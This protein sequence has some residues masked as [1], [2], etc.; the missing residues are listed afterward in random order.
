MKLTKLELKNYKSHKHY[1]ALFNGNTIIQGN[2]G[3][4]KTSLRDAFYWVMT[5]SL[6]DDPTPVDEN[7]QIINHL[8]ISAEVTFDTGLVLKVESAQRWS[9]DVLKANHN[10]TYFVGGTPMIKRDYDNELEKHF[11][12]L[13]Q[14]KIMLD[15]T[16]FAY[17]DGLAI[18]GKTRKTAIQRRR[19]IVIGIANAGNLEDEIA[20]NEEQAKQAKYAI[21][22]LKKEL[23]DANA[24]IES[25][26][27][28][29]VDT[30]HLN[31]ATLK[32]EILGLEQ[33]KTDIVAAMNSVST[34]DTL[35]KAYRDTQLAFDEAKA[36]YSLDYSKRLEQAQKPLQEYMNTKQALQNEY[37]KL[38]Y[39]NRQLAEHERTLIREIDNLKEARENAL[40]E[41]KE[42]QAN[43]YSPESV[44][45]QC[46]GQVLP[47]EKLREHEARFNQDRS[48]RLE[49]IVNYGKEIAHDL[50]HYELELSKLAK[51][52]D[53]ST[54]KNEID[55]LVEPTP[56]LVVAFEETEEHDKL[57]QAV[58][59]ARRKYQ[60]GTQDDAKDFYEQ[61]IA[62][63]NVKINE[64]QLDLN[65]FGT[66]EHLDKEIA[67][68]GIEL[69]EIADRLDAQEELLEQANNFVRQTLNKLENTIRDKFVDIRFKMFDYTL[70]GT[71]KDTCITYGKTDVGYIPWESLSGGQK[72]S[73]TINLANAFAKAWGIELPLWIDDT[74]IYNEDEL[75]A[76]PQLI[77]ITEVPHK[78]LEVV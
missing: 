8:T 16:W 4:G 68:K 74:Q 35:L 31:V 73:A 67:A 23:D 19:E 58:M 60:Q 71:Q 30:Q 32:D 48:S 77:R 76:I 72:R 29:K 14:R 38:E 18:G 66:N 44:T 25:L 24:G 12:T 64:L 3:S 69:G 61:A 17:G 51:P 70:D 22:Q 56:E 37:S 46:C 9:K 75:K 49:R 28:A 21:S 45:C 13:E 78:A 50:A 59:D 53:L 43:V 7:G 41:Y 5:G 62:N 26:H 63:I 39:E 10:M 27:N 1:T 47:P 20:Q 6:V 15:P 11:G 2:K 57:L 33:E 36:K 42:L 55:S 34:D 52:H 65:K 40:A 54:L